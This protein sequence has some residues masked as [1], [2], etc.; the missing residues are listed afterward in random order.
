MEEKDKGKSRGQRLRPRRAR[1]LTE[2]E[3]ELSRKEK[4]ETESKIKMGRKEEGKS[5]GEKNK[6]ENAGQK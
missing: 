1:K 5:R 6:S 2:G 3:R 4:L